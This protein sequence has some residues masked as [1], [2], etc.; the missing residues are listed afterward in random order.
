MLKLMMR[1]AVGGGGGP[2]RAGRRRRPGP[3]PAGAR[4]RA[5]SSAWADARVHWRRRRVVR[6]R[7]RLVRRRGAAAASSVAARSAPAPR[8]RR[9]APRG[10]LRRAP[11]DA[12]RGAHEGRDVEDGRAGSHGRWIAQPE[13]RARRR[14]PAAAGVHGAGEARHRPLVVRGSCEARAACGGRARTCT[15]RGRARRD[16]RPSSATEIS[17]I[18][19]ARPRRAARAWPN[20]APHARRGAGASVG[21]RPAMTVPV[22]RARR[23]CRTPASTSSRETT[24]SRARL[25]RT[26]E[27]NHHA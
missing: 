3:R 21:I 1:S 7:R 23:P 8:R 24:G 13:G 14:A 11:A 5:P 2:R 26:S 22:E 19:A 6:G 10:R 15:A 18:D 20:A 17:A 27:D 12:G 25:L 9:P 4:R 16:A